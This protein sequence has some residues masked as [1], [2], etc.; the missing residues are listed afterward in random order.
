MRPGLRRQLQ[1]SLPA[2]GRAVAE[3]SVAVLQNPCLPA[4]VAGRDR[5]LGP[6]G[7]AGHTGYSRNLEEQRPEVGHLAE[8]LCSFVGTVELLGEHH[9]QPG[10]PRE[11]WREPG[12]AQGHIAAVGTL[13]FSTC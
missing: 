10:H 11:A 1:N 9:K 5:T 4:E 12:P 3:E 7:A 2:V 6:L 8:D 13:F